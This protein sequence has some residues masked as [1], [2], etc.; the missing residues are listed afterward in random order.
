VAQGDLTKSGSSEPLPYDAARSKVLSTM[1][2]AM[3]KNLPQAANAAF[4]EWEKRQK[5]TGD[6]TGSARPPQKNT[7]ILI[8]LFFYS[9]F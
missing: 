1:R 2:T 9:S 7:V 6:L 8:F 4:F 3:E 5:G